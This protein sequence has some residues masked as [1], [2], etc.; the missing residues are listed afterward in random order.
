M[1]KNGQGLASNLK[2]VSMVFLYH[3]KVLVYESHNLLEPQITCPSV[4]YPAQFLFDEYAV[5]DPRI[6]PGPLYKNESGKKEVDF[7]RGGS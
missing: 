5:K 7:L 2:S 3:F 4:K 6:K 1:L